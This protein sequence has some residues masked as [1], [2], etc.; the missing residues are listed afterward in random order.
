MSSDV[1]IFRRLRALESEV[2]RLR[3]LEFVARTGSFTPSLG[4]SSSN[5]TISAYTVQTGFY[6]RAGVLVVAW[7]RIILGTVTAP[8]TGA[9]TI[10]GLPATA[11]T[12]ANATGALIVT[13][14]SGVNV[15]AGAIQLLGYVD[16][17]SATGIVVEMQDDAAPD[18]TGASR[19]ATGDDLGFMAVYAAAA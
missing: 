17:A 5:P 18:A 13:Y 8:G 9:I 10:T 1:E 6:A 3:A 14:A 16:S 11:R 7:G 12:D 19:V 4:G 2:G 15:S